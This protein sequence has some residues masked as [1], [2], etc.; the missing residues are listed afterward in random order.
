MHMLYTLYLDRCKLFSFG[1]VY[2]PSWTGISRLVGEPW[3]FCS[4]LRVCEFW[5]RSR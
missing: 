3:Q 4:I 2:Q 1:G 5:I